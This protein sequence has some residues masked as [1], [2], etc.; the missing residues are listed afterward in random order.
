MRKKLLLFH[1]TD[2]KTEARDVKSFAQGH[3]TCK[4]RS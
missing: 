2:K 1:F 4:W 3:L